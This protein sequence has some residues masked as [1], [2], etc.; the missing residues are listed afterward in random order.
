MWF[1]ETFF[2]QNGAEERSNNFL[3]EQSLAEQ[4]RAVTLLLGKSS[5]S[6]AE[7]LLYT[8][9]DQGSNSFA[10]KTLPCLGRALT[11]GNISLEQGC[12]LLHLLGLWSSLAPDRQNTFPHELSTPWFLDAKIP[13]HPS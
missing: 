6:L 8:T 3:P 7:L 4:S 9:Q 5:P 1:G 12:K 10:G 2:H 11:L 13:F